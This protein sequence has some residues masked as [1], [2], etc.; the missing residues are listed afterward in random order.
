VTINALEIASF[1]T[2]ATISGKSIS[3]NKPIAAISGCTCGFTRGD[4]NYEAVDFDT[5]FHIP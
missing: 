2:N 5:L 1:S 4:C 3:A